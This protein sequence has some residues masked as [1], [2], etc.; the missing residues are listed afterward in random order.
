MTGMQTLLADCDPDQSGGCDYDEVMNTLKRI[1]IEPLFNF[2]DR[3]NDGEVSA[4]DIK[5]I[6][7][8]VGEGTADMAVAFCNIDKQGA[9]S[10]NETMELANQNLRPYFSFMDKN[11]DDALNL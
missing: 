8:F 10:L 6:N 2:M 4:D 7:L 1:A 3:N 11:G 5:F 9:C